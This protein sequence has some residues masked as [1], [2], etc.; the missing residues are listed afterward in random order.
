MQMYM[1]EIVR[2]CFQYA[3]LA[4][5]KGELALDLCRAEL[6]VHVRYHRGHTQYDPDYAVSGETLLQKQERLQ[7]EY[8]S[9]CGQLDQ[10]KQHL[11][12][13][14]YELPLETGASTVRR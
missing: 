12:R 2:A 1:S 14:G 6:A 13:N 11:S 9:V 10:L 3:Q 7:M 5:L 8:D 4:E